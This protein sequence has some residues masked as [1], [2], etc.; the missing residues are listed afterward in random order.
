MP[1]SLFLSLPFYG[2]GLV[3]SFS[4]FVL[5]L[6]AAVLACLLDVLCCAVLSVMYTHTLLVFFGPGRLGLGLSWLAGD[7]VVGSP[8]PPGSLPWTGFSCWALEA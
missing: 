8:S 1:L 4:P 7:G 3:F 5:D 6:P 2:V